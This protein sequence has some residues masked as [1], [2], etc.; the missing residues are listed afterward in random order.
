MNRQ[1]ATQ[2]VNK[3]SLQ[4]GYQ[5]NTDI[6]LLNNNTCMDAAIALRMDALYESLYT[7]A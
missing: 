6:L 1:L 7:S 2:A 4:I 5:S 3:A